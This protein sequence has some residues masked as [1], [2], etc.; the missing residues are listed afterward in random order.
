MIEKMKKLTFLV[1][2]RE[3]NEFIEALRQQ[4]VVHVKQL[5]Q[6]ASSAELQR[7]VDLDTRYANALKLLDAAEKTYT[8][9]PVT[10]D[11]QPSA[12]AEA[13][14]RRVEDIQHIEQKLMHEREAI[15]KDIQMLMPWGDFDMEALKK[16]AKS[17]GL[18]VNFFRS[19]SKYFRKE[20][21]EQY[22]AIPVARRHL[23]YKPSKYFCHKGLC[24][25]KRR[26]KQMW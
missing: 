23:T 4:G 3:Y 1:T 19:S 24:R 26:K 14:L 12:G 10:S 13:I 17:S 22:F 15:E 25:E 2:G 7:A 16:V 6:G 11:V 5:Q 18:Q 9:S 8:V 20:W 21:G